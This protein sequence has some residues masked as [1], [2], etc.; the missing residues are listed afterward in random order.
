[1]GIGRK[2]RPCS[3]ARHSGDLSASKCTETNLRHPGGQGP[4]FLGILVRVSGPG[5]RSGS[6]S[7]VAASRRWTG[8]QLTIT[9]TA[10]VKWLRNRRERSLLCAPPDI[11]TWVLSFQSKCTRCVSGQMRAVAFP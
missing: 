1:M 3:D 5:Q 7:V 4:K 8:A 10:A 2:P 11:Q 9:Q 6:K